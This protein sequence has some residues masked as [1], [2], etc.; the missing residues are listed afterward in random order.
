MPA[1]ITLKSRCLQSLVSWG[2][3]S[4]FLLPLVTQLM[5]MENAFPGGMGTPPL[6][7]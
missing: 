6:G 3:S 4:Q 5:E 1:I 2:C 7:L